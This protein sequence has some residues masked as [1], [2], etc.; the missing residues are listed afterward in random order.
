M[1]VLIDTNVLLRL[2][3]KRQ[4]DKS[5][6]MRA[7]LQLKAQRKSLYV[8]TQNLI[9]YW[10]V[11]TRPA[12][13]NGLGLTVAEVVAELETLESIFEVLPDSPSVFPVW[14]RLV[15]AYGISGKTSHDTRLVATM[16]VHGVTEIL[17]FNDR[18]F[19]QFSGISVIVPQG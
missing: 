17:T 5:V 11:A 2:G 15:E 12:A 18:D 8:A 3:V 19:R 1:S 14:R 9:E 16:E 7:V 6:A 10:V 4:S 13:S